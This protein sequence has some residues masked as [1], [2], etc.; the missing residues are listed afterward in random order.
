[1][2]AARFAG[3]GMQLQEKNRDPGQRQR[4]RGSAAKGDREAK[5]MAMFCCGGPR[6]LIGGD[7]E[8]QFPRAVESS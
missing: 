4:I 1:M 3:D 6:G 7:L 5:S 8:T 2:R